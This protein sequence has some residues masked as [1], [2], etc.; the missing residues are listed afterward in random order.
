MVGE[1]NR[2][3]DWYNT[4][5]NTEI[6]PYSQPIFDKGRGIQ[7]GKYSLFNERHWISTCKEITPDIDLIHVMS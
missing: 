4:V 5:Q 2:Q 1:Q 7:W 3:I 6:D